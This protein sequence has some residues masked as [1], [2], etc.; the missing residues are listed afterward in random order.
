MQMAV[1]PPAPMQEK[2]AAQ[3]VLAPHGKAH[4]PTA[5]LHLWVPQVASLEQGSA[6]GLGCA[7]P[8]AGAGCGAAWGWGWG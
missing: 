5:V 4:L 1:G 6:S 3:S 8:G 7:P 2:P